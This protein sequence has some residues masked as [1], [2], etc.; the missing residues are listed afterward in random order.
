MTDK[1]D[2]L[3]AALAPRAERLQFHGVEVEV[4]E[5]ATAADTE[6]FRNGEDAQFKFLTRCAFDGDGQ[7]LFTDAQIPALKA[8]SRAKLMPL[9]EAVLRVNGLLAEAEEKNSAASPAGK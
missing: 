4:R 5:L 3:L 7:P 2:L 1:T 9:L 6:A 8:A